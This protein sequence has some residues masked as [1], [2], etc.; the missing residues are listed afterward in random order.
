MNNLGIASEQLEPYGPKVPVPRLLEALNKW[1]H[2]SEV[3][4]YDDS[5]KEIREQLPPIWREMVNAAVVAQDS[6][7]GK[8][9]SKPWRILDFGCGTGFEAAQLLTALPSD[10]VAELVCYDLS[11]EMLSQCKLRLA[12]LP[13]RVHFTSCLDEVMQLP[14]EFNLLATN[15][16][17]HHLPEPFETLDRL[18]AKLSP[19]A[20]W[21]GGHEPSR[22][23]YLN[24][25]CREAY[26]RF[27]TSHQARRWIQP[28]RIWQAARR[29]VGWAQTPARFAADAAVE[30]GML[31]R[32][33]PD[34]LVSQLV[35]LHVARSLDDAR[36]G[37]GFDTNEMQQQLQPRWEL[38]WER[39][40]SFMGPFYEGR[41]SKH[42]QG[43]AQDLARKHP[44]D[45]ANFS[46]VW[47]LSN[48]ASREA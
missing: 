19:G 36:S 6:A 4:G 31:S 22:R 15:S 41:L 38:V 5:H 48:D 23:F 33:L 14:G 35:D 30:E 9:A 16:V 27:F 40:Y 44:R 26:Q 37:K 2:A 1:Y 43:V 21:L 11:P 45:G 34:R 20:F 39:T 7:H 46:A 32:Q 18:T 12:P 42:W 28:A 3:G 24:D 13:H 8:H 29:K 25:A 17:L 10:S 47:R